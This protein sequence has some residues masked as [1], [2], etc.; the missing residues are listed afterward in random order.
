M[1]LEKLTIPKFEELRHPDILREP[2]LNA[3]R[4][5]ALGFWLV[6]TP[7]FLL[8]CLTMKYLIGW[9]LG[10]IQHLEDFL[11]ALDRD[12]AGFWLSPLLL[13]LAP[14]VA[15]VLNMLAVLHFH[16]DRSRNELI[17]SVKL[18]WLNLL[19]AA[20]AIGILGVFLLYALV[21]NIHHAT[22]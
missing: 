21:E 12:G 14:A 9:K 1:E 10:F 18:R 3:R 8:A 5:A 15:F 4:S 11:S 13:A 19:L 16:F 7:A 6:A 20:A 22:H 17:I 2:I